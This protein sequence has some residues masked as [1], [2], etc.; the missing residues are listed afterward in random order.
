M[1]ELHLNPQVTGIS[2]PM[3]RQ[4]I[5]APLF[6]AL[7]YPGITLYFTLTGLA[8]IQTTILT[9]VYQVGLLSLSLWAILLVRKSRQKFFTIQLTDGLLIAFLIMFLYDVLFSKHEQPLQSNL[10]L[11]FGVCWFGASVARS[12]TFDQFKI[13]CRISSM[14]ACITSLALALQVLAGGAAWVG[15]GSRLAAGASGNPVL[16]GYTGAFAFLSS[17]VFFTVS[18]SS[19]KPFWLI[20]GMAGLFVCTSSGTR[21]ATVS[22]V[23]AGVFIVIYTLGILFGSNKAT[24]NLFSN[25]FIVV[26]AFLFLSLMLPPMLS[27]S[28][29]STTTDPSP[30]ISVLENATTR[31]NAL[32]QVAE[33]GRGDLAIQ[34]RQGFYTTAWEIFIKN[35]IWGGGVYAAGNAHNAFLQV[36][37]EFG[38]LGIVTFV[39]P[40]FYLGYRAFQA[41]LHNLTKVSLLSPSNRSLPLI[42]SDYSVMTCFA[43]IFFL[44]AMSLFSFHGTPYT[45]TFPVFSLG[46]LIA[47]SRLKR[48]DIS[49]P[50]FRF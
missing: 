45:N 5:L 17:L 25:T 33:G 15:N 30:L 14:I 47:F 32:F 19:F 38:I 31:I 34:E 49:N 44:Q 18:K 27:S 3:Q 13:F 24:A 6:L 50:G 29:A 9:A 39:L 4:V 42:K 43:I 23:T 37:S 21:S 22:M 16:A 11:Y 12:L 2:R 28:T 40:L 46:L 41:A 35:P 36:A 26:G 1:N 7:Y 20:A 10:F 48:T 8:G